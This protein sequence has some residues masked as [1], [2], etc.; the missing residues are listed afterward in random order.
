MNRPE[1]LIGNAGDRNIGD[2]DLLLAEQMEQEV[3]RPGEPIEFDDEAGAQRVG[4]GIGLERGEIGVRNGARADQGHG[5]D[6]SG[7]H[8]DNSGFNMAPSGLQA[9]GFAGQD[10]PK[11]SE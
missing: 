10:L 6:R 11:L 9:K 1:E 5:L 8:S 7:G 3:E 4:H 2:V